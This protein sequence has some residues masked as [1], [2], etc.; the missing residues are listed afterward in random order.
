MIENTEE[1]YSSIDE[2]STG[3]LI[4]GNHT[5]II[6][7]QQRGYRWRVRNLLEL[8]GDLID[9]VEAPDTTKYCLQPLAVSK[10]EDHYKVWDGQQRLTTLKILCRVLGIPDPYTFIYER[11]LDGERARFLVNPAFRGDEEKN[12]DFFYIGRGFEVLRHCVENNVDSPLINREN[13]TETHLFINICRRLQEPGMKDK[14]VSLILDRLPGKTLEFLW[15]EVCE[16]KATEIFRDI[17]SGKISLTNPE[18]IKA[19]LLGKNSGIRNTA[20]AGV[21]FAEIEKL[22]LDD[23]FWYMIQSHETRMRG[24]TAERI[25]NLKFA[26]DMK[27]RLM[28]MDFLFNLVA[29]VSYEQYLKDPIAS[30]RYFYD[31]KGDIARLWNEVRN[32]YDILRTLYSDI[33]AYHYIGFLTYSHADSAK[34]AYSR[35]SETIDLYAKSKKDEFMRQLKKKISIKDPDSLDFNKH[36]K[37]L[38][39]VLL[40]HNIETILHNFKQQKENSRLHLDRPFEV[41]PFELL[42]RQEWN[43]EHI[44]PATDNPLKKE[45]DRE[46]WIESAKFDYQDLFTLPSGKKEGKISRFTDEERIKV[47]EAMDA[48]RTAQETGD[49]KQIT[50]AFEKL[51]SLVIDTI[52]SKL[53]DDKVQEKY[54]IGNYALLDETTNKSFHNALFPTKRR[55]IIAATGQQVDIL[56]KEVKL[57]YIPPCTKAAFMKFY[58]TRP[59]VSLSEWTETDVKDYR[60]NILDHVEKFIK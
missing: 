38:R 4:A 46:Q 31:N 41:F 26:V 30:F 12:I 54:C 17:N 55:I 9:F 24:N 5:F 60:K 44:A 3:Q 19:L 53:G 16:D 32:K 42:Y 51:Y 11:D 20:L 40:L 2:K 50:A 49:K 39:R 10:A 36:K 8:M 7:Y 1:F 22:M 29:G 48:Y 47:A 23:H 56:D 21:Q 43:I 27:S 57:V 45:D 28:R 6:P 59:S 52:E 35:I 15:Y 34:G 13:T 37:E 58:N 33:E 14:I 18:L 25:S